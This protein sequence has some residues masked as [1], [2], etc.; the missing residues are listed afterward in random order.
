MNDTSGV[1]CIDLRLTS[2]SDG[3]IRTRTLDELI[4]GLRDTGFVRLVGHGVD[5]DLIDRVHG[6]FSRFFDLDL[7]RK[8]ESG[9]VA[10]GQRGYTPFGVEHAR[11]AQ[12]ADQKEFFHVGQELPACSPLRG[13][14]PANVWPAAMP[15]LR[16]D[17][18]ALYRAL[19]RTAGTLLRAIAL[20]SSLPSEVFASMITEGNSIL[21]AVHYP[22]LSSDADPR[23]MRAAP[24]EDINLITLLCGAT[25][26][27]LELRTRADRWIEVPSRPGE[28]VA[29]VGDMLA[30]LTNGRLPSTS[31]RVVARGASARRHRYSLP[32]FAHPRPE[33]DLSVMADFVTDDDP[34]RFPPITARAFLAER[35][36]EIGLVS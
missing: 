20:A 28:I 9:G 2:A 30:R 4:G 29:D 1:P 8:L 31:H 27:G 23:A 3:A 26:S 6:L 22:P 5:D 13:E 18:L 16:R 15:D 32:F 21:R 34:A 24:H 17:A 11:D 35:L 14:Y 25:D 10:G 19:E 7:H 33:C 12:V 36:R